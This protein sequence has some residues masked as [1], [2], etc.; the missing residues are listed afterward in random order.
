MDICKYRFS[1]KSNFDCYWYL[2]HSLFFYIAKDRYMLEISHFTT[3]QLREINTIIGAL[4][5]LTCFGIIIS[6]G[7]FIRFSGWLQPWIETVLVIGTVGL[8]MIMSGI[9][10]I[11]VKMQQRKEQSIK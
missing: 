9:L 2:L 8:Y 10:A 11:V 3:A 7:L 4:V 5:G 1:K 6:F